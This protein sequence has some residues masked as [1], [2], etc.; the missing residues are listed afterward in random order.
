MYLSL[1]L[2]ISRRIYIHNTIGPI[3]RRRGEII[4]CPTQ[5]G[6]VMH[7]SDRLRAGM[8]LIY[9]HIKSQI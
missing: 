7:R 6:D 3:E 4:S 1:S 5:D 9:R 2:P 8:L